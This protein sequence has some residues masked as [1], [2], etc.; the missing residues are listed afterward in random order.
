MVFSNE[1]GIYRPGIRGIRLENAVIIREAGGGEFGDFLGFETLTFLP[2]E[3]SAVRIESLT[4]EERHWLERYH[5]E[6]RG[7]LRPLLS[8][9]ENVWLEGKTRLPK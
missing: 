8:D 3:L 6:V 2:F 5:G 7:K 9:E 1:P 4:D